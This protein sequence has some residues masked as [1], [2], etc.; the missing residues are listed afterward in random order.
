M[1][2]EQNTRRIIFP[3]MNK[4][5]IVFFAVALL[6]AGYWAFTVMGYI[7]DEGVKK[8]GGIYIDNNTTFEQIEEQLS[9]KKILKEPKA[10]K[11]VAK[12]K[13]YA[14]SIKPGYYFF[15][16]GMNTNQMINKLRSGDQTA[17]KLT[18][19]NIRL[20]EGLAG[21]LA[22]QIQAD[23]LAILNALSDTVLMDKYGFRAE[24]FSAMFIPNTYKVYWTI[25]PQKLVE[26]MN[27]EYNRFWNES[28]K[29]KAEAMNLSPIAVTTIASIIQE[30]TIK[31]E[32]KPIIAGVYIN[33][34]K[35]RMPLQACP[36]VKYALN[37]FSIRRVLTKHKKIESPYNTYKHTGVPPGPINYPDISSIDAVLNF[38]A[39]KYLYFCA[40]EDFSG[41][42]NF[43]KT[44]RQHA[45]NARKYQREL[46]KKRIY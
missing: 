30:E 1:R 19:N 7:F 34:L 15:K 37:D 12:K 14:D 29:R 2:I 10:F 27:K 24:T 11:W 4:S 8:A 46:N 41:Y 3:K 36:T 21:K 23:S 45:K 32:E 9:K 44:Y 40:K 39:H 38:K 28:R 13:K 16:K 43:A 18:F 20:K 42:H 33:R 35:K 25:S 26:R 6:A 31:S 5:I 17:V 22:K